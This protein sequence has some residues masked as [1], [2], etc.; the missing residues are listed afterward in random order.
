MGGL[1]GI[2]PESCAVSNGYGDG[3]GNGYGD[4]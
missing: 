1:I 4:G 2:D 3:D